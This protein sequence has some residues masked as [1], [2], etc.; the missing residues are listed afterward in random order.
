M[1]TNKLEAGSEHELGGLSEA[2]GKASMIPTPQSASLAR[3]GMVLVK[4]SSVDH[5]LSSS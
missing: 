2:Q 4:R 1:L 5:S 3:F